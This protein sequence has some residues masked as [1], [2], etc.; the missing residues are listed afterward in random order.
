[1]Y[2][3]KETHKKVGYRRDRENEMLR[4]YFVSCVQK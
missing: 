4:L 3:K 1:M 2:M